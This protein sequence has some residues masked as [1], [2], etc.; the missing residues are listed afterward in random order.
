ML[1]F[2]CNLRVRAKLLLSFFSVLI[3]TSAASVSSLIFIDNTLE[4]VEQTDA[5]LSRD[6]EQVS[7]VQNRLAALDYKIYDFLSGRIT[8]QSERTKAVFALIDEIKV[9]EADIREMRASNHADKEKLD[10]ARNLALEWARIFRTRAKA[11]LLIG[12][13]EGFSVVYNESLG[14]L[15]NQA[16]SVCSD[17]IASQHKRITSMT[18]KLADSPVRRDIIIAMT[19]SLIASIVIALA[20]SGN[21]LSH[22]RYCSDRAQRIAAGELDIRIKTR[23]HDEFGELIMAIERMKNAINEHIGTVAEQTIE[24]VARLNQISVADHAISTELHEHQNHAVNVSS[25]VNEMT[26]TTAEIARSCESAA[27]TSEQT[28]DATSHGISSARNTIERIRAQAVNTR[29][30]ADNIAALVD[31]SRSISAIVTTIED[32]ASKTNLLAL[33]AAIEAARAGAAGRGF[34]VVAD[35][36]CALAAQTARSTSQIR[37]TIESVQ[38]N[39]SSCLESMNASVANIESIAN[40][41]DELQSIFDDILAKVDSLNDQV[42]R[43]ST[44]AEQQHCSTGEISKNICSITSTSQHI[45]SMTTDNLSALDDLVDRV[46]NMQKAVSYFRTEATVQMMAAA[47]AYAKDGMDSDANTDTGDD[48]ACCAVKQP[49]IPAEGTY[50]MSGRSWS[51]STNTAI[52]AAGSIGTNSI[53]T[54]TIGTGTTGAGSSV[55]GRSAATAGSYAGSTTSYH[56]HIGSASAMIETMMASQHESGAD[57]TNSHLRDVTAALIKSA[58]DHKQASHVSS[59]V[60][61]A[62]VSRTAASFSS[63]TSSSSSSATGSSSSS[64]TSM[65]SSSGSGSAMRGS[66]SYSKG[67][68]L[69][70]YAAAGSTIK[71]LKSVSAGSVSG[72]AASAH[73]FNHSSPGTTVH[74]AGAI[75]MHQRHASRS[76]NGAGNYTSAQLTTMAPAA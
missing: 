65:R 24:V 49:D 40:E 36:V 69:S 75:T 3:L 35:E 46:F 25:A 11:Q 72:S 28:H 45:S 74:K 23:T 34:A 10:K 50:S 13:I 71:S 51:T 57:Y 37:A 16:Y 76:V 21:I 30:D 54:N 66:G 32:I 42:T 56:R 58:A 60:R 38:K 22:L 44:S 47:A 26:S 17:I 31:H 2:L 68:L 8:D 29:N 18:G 33:N 64:G 14:P 27:V 43:I 52:S 53:G 12:S 61:S 5:L 70:A 15:N 20:I 39:T 48:A 9:F 4:V 62:A 41:A 63:A 55:G 7:G 1:K 19:A 67:S 6:Y 73:G 59:A